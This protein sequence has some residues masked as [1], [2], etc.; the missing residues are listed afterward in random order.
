L[1]YNDDQLASDVV[2]KKVSAYYKQKLSTIKNQKKGNIFTLNNENI[3]SDLDLDT[4]LSKL[5]ENLAKSEGYLVFIKKYLSQNLVRINLNE[6][7]ID[8]AIERTKMHKQKLIDMSVNNIF[9]QDYVFTPRY[10]HYRPCCKDYCLCE[11]DIIQAL[12]LLFLLNNTHLN[13]YDIH[14]MTLDRLEILQ[15][16]IN[17][18]S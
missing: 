6:G 10:S 14:K 3:V 13:T 5:Y 7:D 11:M 17:L 15:I 12:L 8:A 9:S 16:P 1:N 4:K 2:F 18:L